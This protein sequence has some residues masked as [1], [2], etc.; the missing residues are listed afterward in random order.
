MLNYP[1]FSVN[2]GREG[3]ILLCRTGV[4]CNVNTDNSIASCKH[5]RHIHTFS[6]SQPNM[7]IIYLLPTSPAYYR[8][9][10]KPPQQ[11]K[12]NLNND[13]SM[14]S[15]PNCIILPASANSNF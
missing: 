9:N 8:V 1:S 11:L 13:L 4:N 6:W 14:L 3:E 10:S 5:L 7:V 15:P 12:I 2:I